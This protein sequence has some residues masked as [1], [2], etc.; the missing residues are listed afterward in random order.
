VPCPLQSAKQV[1]G[2]SITQRIKEIY[3]VQRSACCPQGKVN[4]LDGRNRDLAATR[5]IAEKIL[6]LY[7]GQIVEEAPT[8]ML[9]RRP[10]HP[11]TQGLLAAIP[12]TEPGRLAP[13]LAGES[14][15]PLEG[16]V[17]CP[18]EPRCL[19]AHDRCGS[20]MTKSQACEGKTVVSCHFF[21]S[22]WI[23]TM[24]YEAKISIHQGA[25]VEDDLLI[26]RSQWIP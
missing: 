17:G 8:E 11:H 12:T 10:L 20:D 4:D 25:R 7:L 2:R 26:M 23:R 14:P 15:A 24:D 9:Y 6:V 5:L 19:M 21:L 16:D 22:S 3:V 13:M 1:L 18:S